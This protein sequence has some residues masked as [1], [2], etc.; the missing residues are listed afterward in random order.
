MSKPIDYTEVKVG[1]EIP[2]KTLKIDQ[3]FI[4]N[5]AHICGDYNPALDFAE[6]NGRHPFQKPDLKPNEKIVIWLPHEK[7]KIHS[8][9]TPYLKTDS[10]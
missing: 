5:Y 6:Y 4:D 9:E 3:E 7:E 2:V 8:Q 10:D 1:D